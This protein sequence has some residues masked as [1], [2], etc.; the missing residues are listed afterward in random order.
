MKHLIF[1][2]YKNIFLKLD[3][4]FLHLIKDLMIL[5]MVFDYISHFQIS[6]LHILIYLFFLIYFQMILFLLFLINFHRKMAQKKILLFFSKFININLNK[7][8]FQF[9]KIFKRSLFI[10]LFLVYSFKYF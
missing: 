10:K 9:Q 1:Q 2:N 3:H 5:L 8:F 7:F 6:V 4:T